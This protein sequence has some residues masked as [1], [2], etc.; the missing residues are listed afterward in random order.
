ML[1]NVNRTGRRGK[2]I[3]R[4]CCLKNSATRHKTGCDF[5]PYSHFA[6]LSVGSSRLSASE[7]TCHIFTSLMTKSQ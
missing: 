7:L 6:A 2:G 1:Y 3:R 4:H 5:G